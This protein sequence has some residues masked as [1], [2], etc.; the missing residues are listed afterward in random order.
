MRT[1]HPGAI[2]PPP[3]EGFIML[4]SLIVFFVVL[5]C[6]SLILLSLA[7]FSRRSAELS[8]QIQREITARNE[9][10]MSGLK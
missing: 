9:Q 2:R 6:F 8:I 10:V 3:E 5:F 1:L 7:S 4:R